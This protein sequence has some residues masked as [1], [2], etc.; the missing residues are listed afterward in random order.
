[1]AVSVRIILW[2]QRDTP[3]PL[4]LQLVTK[5]NFDI[6]RDHSRQKLQ[7]QA[8]ASAGVT[9]PN[10]GR[11]VLPWLSE[12]RCVKSS[13]TNTIC[14]ALPPSQHKVPFTLPV[15]NSLLWW[16]V[17]S[18]V[19][20]KSSDILCHK[21]N[22]LKFKRIENKCSMCFFEAAAVLLDLMRTIGLSVKCWWNILF[23]FNHK[24]L[25]IFLQ[26]QPDCNSELL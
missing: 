21:A 5:I 12:T 16:S 24:S 8:L 4:P 22:I 23:E 20:W 17:L 2:V 18:R 1:M 6:C 13:N 14:P 19:S 10:P 7:G 25:R 9:K 15:S 11:R 26:I 3:L